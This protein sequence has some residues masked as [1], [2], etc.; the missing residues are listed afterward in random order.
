MNAEDIPDQREVWAERLERVRRS[1]KRADISG[2]R[3]PPRDP[4][5]RAFLTERGRL[6]PFPEDPDLPAPAVVRRRR[7]A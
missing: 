5:E 1:Q 3:R 7:P 6:G 4:A 2:M